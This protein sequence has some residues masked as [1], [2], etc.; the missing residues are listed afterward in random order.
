MAVN[1]I[2]KQFLEAEDWKTWK[3]ADRIDIKKRMMT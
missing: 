2:F 1:G 3:M